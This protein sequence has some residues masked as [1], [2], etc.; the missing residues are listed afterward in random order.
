LELILGFVLVLE[1]LAPKG[2][3]VKLPVFFVLLVSVLL[4]SVLLR[5]DIFCLLGFVALVSFLPLDILNVGMGLVELS[6]AE[7]VLFALSGDLA[8]PPHETIEKA[9]IKVNASCK[10]VR[11]VI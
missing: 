5:L 9:I 11:I 8:S 10:I 2:L 7:V 6:S 1:G 3:L 4:V